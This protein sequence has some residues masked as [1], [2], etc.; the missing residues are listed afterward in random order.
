ML[1]AFTPLLFLVAALVVNVHVYGDRS[2]EGSNQL[3]LLASAG[4]AA[5]LAPKDR[6]TQLW[7]GIQGTISDST[8][9]ILI[10]LMVG[11]LAGTWM[12]SGIIPTLI[13]YGLKLFTPGSF[14]LAAAVL[15]AAVSLATGSSWSTSATVGIAL[16][17]IGQSLGLSPGWIAGAVV[18]GAYFGDKMSPVSDTTNIAAAMAGAELTDH[19]RHMLWTSGPAILIA[20]AVFGI[21]GLSASEAGD[22]SQV[23]IISELLRAKFTISLWLLL[24]PVVSIVLIARN[25]DALAAMGIG[26][27][28]GALAALW[29]Q[30]NIIAEIA[31]HRGP[32]AWYEGIT[33]AMYGNTQIAID[34]PMLAELLKGKGMAGM[35]GTVWLILCALTFGGIMDAAGFLATLT[36]GLLRVAHGAAGLIGATLASCGLINLTASDQY[37]AIVVP[38]RMFKKAFEERGLKPE[39][40]SRALED[41]GTVTSALVPWNTCGAYQSSVLGVATGDY[42]MYAIFNW[43]SPLISMLLAATGWTITRTSSGASTK[44]SSPQ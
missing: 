25:V 17:G 9:A 10:L 4:I 7:H 27:L 42:F 13:V 43:M 26:T 41:S 16:M 36:K 19:I 31:G 20:F 33:Q 1:R 3:I 2:L 34:H 8:K 14:L 18:S 38:G 44:P 24:I 35:L 5:L 29:L 15:S 12:V 23:A 11:A 39:N 30:P 21:K 32:S 28:A 40:L 37:L 6:K 22:L